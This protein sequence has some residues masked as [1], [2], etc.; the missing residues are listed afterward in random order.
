MEIDGG[1]VTDNHIFGLGTQ[2]VGN[3]VSQFFRLIDPIQF[4]PT[5]ASQIPPTFI[6]HPGHF[7]RYGFGH[8]PHRIRIKVDRSCFSQQKLGAQFPERII[9]IQIHTMLQ[10]NLFHHFS[11]DSNIA[12]ICKI[13]YSWAALRA[14]HLSSSISSVLQAIMLIRLPEPVF[15]ENG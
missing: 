8:R 6:E 12:L 15:S 2:Q 3:P 7:F 4:R 10:F 14:R 13:S 1:I 9:G 11:L 5:L